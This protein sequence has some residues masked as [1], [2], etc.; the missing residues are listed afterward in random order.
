MTRS[1]CAVICLVRALVRS[2]WAL[3]TSMVVRWPPCAS[4]R[5]PCSAI[6][7]AFTSDSAARSATL[8]PSLA[9]Q[10]LTPPGRLM[11]CGIDR[12]DLRDGDQAVDGACRGERHRRLADHLG[13]D[14]LADRE[15][16]LS[17]VEVGKA[18][19]QP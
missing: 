13:I 18:A 14:F 7:A 17:G 15:P 1:R 19:A 16:N 6:S 12:G 10:P 2:C 9:T 5:T 4:R 11:A 3:S 8:V